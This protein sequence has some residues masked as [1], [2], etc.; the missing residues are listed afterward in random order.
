MIRIGPNISIWDS[1]IEESF[2]RA[3]GP[4]GQNVNKLSTAVEL[5]FD[6]ARSPGVPGD[7]LE[8]LRAAA[9]RR[10]TIAGVLIIKAERYR[11]QERNRADARA[12]LIALLESVAAAPTRRRVPFPA[13]LKR[14]RLKKKKERGESKRRRRA[15][16]V[17][18]D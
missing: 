10:M 18:E 8:R 15:V 3:S 5:R 17:N 9:G 4:G 16:E 12:R 7:V 2:I 14:R 1:E 13:G 6:A 11:T